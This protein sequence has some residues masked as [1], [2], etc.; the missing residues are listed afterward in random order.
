MKP[1]IS[2]RLGSER[3]T[4]SSTI[5]SAVRMTLSCSKGSFFLLA[6]DAPDMGVAVHVRPLHVDDGHIRDERRH[7]DHLSAGVRVAAPC[8]NSGWHSPGR[9]AAVGFIGM[10]GR[11]V[12]PACRR[13]DHAEVGVLLPFQPPGFELAR[14]MRNEP[15]PGLPM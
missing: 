14:T 4:A 8:G 15:T 12:A 9:R 10:N 7:D 5:S 2:V 11:P 13:D 6:D 3:M 1:G